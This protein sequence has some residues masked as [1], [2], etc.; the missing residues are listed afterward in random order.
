LKFQISD[1]K[2]SQKTAK[3]IRQMSANLKNRGFDLAA[4][5]RET[6]FQI[7]SSRLPVFFFSPSDAFLKYCSS[8]IF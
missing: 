4:P 2:S 6:Y 5:A 8:R 1:F 3:Q 7:F